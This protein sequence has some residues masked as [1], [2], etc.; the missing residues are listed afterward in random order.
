MSLALINLWLWGRHECETNE[1]A[2]HLHAHLL[3]LDGNIIVNHTRLEFWR[4][5]ND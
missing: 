3:E 5:P 2:R 1:A 4:N